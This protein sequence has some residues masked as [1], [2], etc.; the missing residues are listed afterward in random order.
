MGAAI[1]SPQF[2]EEYIN[3]K[4]SKWASNIKTLAEIAKTEPHAAY[5]A[6]LHGEQHKYTYFKRTLLNIDEN[7]K[8]LDEVINN[9]FI[10]SLFGSELSDNE[11]N[12]IAL[13]IREGG[14]GIR[15]VGEN[16]DL[17]FETSI[18]ITQ[19]LVG[20]ILKQSDEV[21]S[22]DDVL[23]ARTNA[24]QVCKTNETARI[25]TTKPLESKQ[26]S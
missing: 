20:E 18:K 14:L 5:A 13:P 15:R 25:E 3:E 8:P 4:V 19:P 23:T 11:R 17:C 6:Y 10:P 26:Q 24:L 9:D 12:V 22:P 7:L 21:P 2:K 1:G 16:S